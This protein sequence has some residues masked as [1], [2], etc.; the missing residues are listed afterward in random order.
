M[1]EYTDKVFVF[2]RQYLWKG[3]AENKNSSGYALDPT[4]KSIILQILK[5]LP[6]LRNFQ[7]HFWHT[8]DSVSF[9]DELRNFIQNKHDWACGQLL[10]IKSLDADLYFKQQDR[11]PLFK[12][13]KFITQEGRIFFLSF[14]LHKGQMQS[15]LQRRKGSKRHDL[16]EYKFKH[17]LFTY[18]CH[19]E[20]SS[21]LATGIDNSILPKMDDDIRNRIYNGRQA[22]RILSYLKDKPLYEKKDSLP[23]VMKDG[24]FVEDMTMLIAY[25][26][27]TNIIPGFHFYEKD[28]QPSQVLPEGKEYHEEKKQHE[29]MVREQFRRFIL[30]DKH[31]YEFEISYSVLRRIVTEILL[32]S[33]KSTTEENGLSSL[34]PIGLILCS[35]KKEEQIEL[36][37]LDQ[38]HIRVAEYMTQ[39]P[40]KEL[41]AGK[42]NMAISAAR[43]KG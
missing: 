20:G 24:R 21:W 31:E 42:L 9:T 30:P 7:S 34:D 40:A 27:E 11:Y 38:G 35:E 29:K 14:F 12:E 33:H 10:E 8:N 13:K 26:E 6:E 2:L 16:P 18:Y 36:L 4:D 23:L 1:N 43:R 22:N 41:L 28:A 15:L 25:I 3:N 19:R 5:K 17:Q 37:E 39:L 32:D